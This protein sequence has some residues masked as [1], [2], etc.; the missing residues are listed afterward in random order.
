MELETQLGLF[1]FQEKKEKKVDV[2]SRVF[3]WI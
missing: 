1:C 2:S 3:G